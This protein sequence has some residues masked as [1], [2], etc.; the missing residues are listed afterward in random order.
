MFAELM[1]LEPIKARELLE[2]SV[3]VVPRGSKPMV[4]LEMSRLEEFEGNVEA[5]V[6]GSLAVLR[7]QCSSNHC[8]RTI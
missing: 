3:Q 5:Y 2:R 6:V 1:R 8:T 7:L 4:L